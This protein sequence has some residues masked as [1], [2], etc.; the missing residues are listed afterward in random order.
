MSNTTPPFQLLSNN[1]SLTNQR[2]AVPI[3]TFMG[4]LSVSPCLLFLYINTIMLY[5]LKSKPMFRETSRYILFGNLLFADTI[6]LLTSQLLYILAVAGL[7][8]IRYICVV[9][10]LV[11]IFT[12]AVSP[13][14]LSVMSL[15]RTTGVVIAVVWILCSL[16]T[17]IKLV[18]LLVLESMPL[19][20]SMQ[21]FCSTSELFHLKIHNQVDNV[22]ISIVFTTVGL[23]IIYS[24]IAMM[25]VAK[26]A[27]ADKDI[28]S[29]ARNTVLLHLIQLGLSL[30]STLVPTIVSALKSRAMDKATQIEYIVFIILIILPRCLSPLIYG[31][32]DKAFRHILMYH[33][34]CGLRCA[35]E[36][37]KISSY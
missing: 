5:S 18:M 32:R 29:K 28:N 3:R 22:F 4:F 2:L 27:S 24:Y 17:I 11:A 25:M 33:L 8:V 30:S 36:P 10:V 34:T 9:I 15:E 37:I 1:V 16:N 14:N 19:D 6:L 7:F 35:V 12:S 20:Q 21:Q 31:L 23:I 13:L 26:S